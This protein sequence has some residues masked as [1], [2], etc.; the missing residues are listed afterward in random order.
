MGAIY[1]RLVRLGKNQEAVHFNERPLF[2]LRNNLVPLIEIQ[3]HIIFR[4]SD[5]S[6]ELLL[7]ILG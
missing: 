5:W 2:I 6:L 3:G 7:G 1:I 4:L